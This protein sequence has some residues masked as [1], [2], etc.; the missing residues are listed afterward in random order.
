MANVSKPTFGAAIAAASMTAMTRALI[1]G[2]TALTLSAAVASVQAGYVTDGAG[3]PTLLGGPYV[4]DV[5]PPPPPA[6]TPPLYDYAPVPT[7]KSVTA[8][9]APVPTMKWV[10]APQPEPSTT[11]Q[12]KRDHH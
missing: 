3:N 4:V 2:V 1:L 8:P 7:T 6:V 9:E 10:T 11:Q 12:V 5:V